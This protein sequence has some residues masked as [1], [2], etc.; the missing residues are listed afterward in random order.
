MLIVHGYIIQRLL[1]NFQ[2]IL[3]GQ[4]YYSV[5]WDV[6]HCRYCPIMHA[7]LLIMTFPIFQV[8]HHLRI[9]TPSKHYVT[10]GIFF[11]FVHLLVLIVMKVHI[12]V[13]KCRLSV[14]EVQLVIPM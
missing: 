1:T 6:S 5:L 10:A 7:S 13:W 9:D 3:L 2:L 4:Y 11:L 12:G 14:V 8:S